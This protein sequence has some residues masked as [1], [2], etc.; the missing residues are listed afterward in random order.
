M[1]PG[2]ADSAEGQLDCAGLRQA[3]AAT[4]RE[5][6]AYESTIAANRGHNQAVGYVS[7]V[8]LPPLALALRNDDDA[9]AALNRL[10]LQSDRI[11]RLSKA[12]RCGAG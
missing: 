4:K 11:D 2:D 5:I 6:A 10:Q 9:K 8:L 7:A 12:R 1:L 3:A